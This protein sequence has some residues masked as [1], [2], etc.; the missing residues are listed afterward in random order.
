[1]TLFIFVGEASPDPLVVDY[2]IIRI[3]PIVAGIG[4]LLSIHTASFDWENACTETWDSEC[5]FS[6]DAVAKARSILSKM[7]NKADEIT[8]A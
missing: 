1:M 2:N 3:A 7:M 4:D 6:A 5:P 8:I